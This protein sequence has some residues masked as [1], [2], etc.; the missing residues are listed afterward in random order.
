M[1]PTKPSSATDLL[2]PPP[3]LARLIV[4]EHFR[5]LSLI[6]RLGL[7]LRLVTITRPARAATLEIGLS[8]HLRK[9]LGLACGY[10]G[11]EPPHWY[12]PPL[13]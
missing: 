7:A 2:S 5:H 1:T 11:V 12:P 13:F 3:A 9:D 6:R 4:E 10:R 8:D